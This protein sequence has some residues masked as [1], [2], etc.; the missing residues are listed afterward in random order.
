[1]FLN[2][3]FRIVNN[4]KSS[5]YPSV[6]KQLYKLWYINKTEFNTAIKNTSSDKEEQLPWKNVNKFLFSLH[7]CFCEVAYIKEK[8]AFLVC[9]WEC[10]LSQTQML[11]EIKK[12]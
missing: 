3:L 9:Q 10:H 5:K 12:E 4:H 2:V 6:E 8:D 1:M 11:I 7:H